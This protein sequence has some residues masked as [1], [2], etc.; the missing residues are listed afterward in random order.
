MTGPNWPSSGE[1]DIIEGVNTGSQN[2]MTMHTSDGCSLAGSDCEGNTG[3]PVI[4]GGSSSYGSGLNSA[5]G[6]MYAM[7]WTSSQISIWFFSHGSEPG[8]INSA[9]PN[10]SNWGT[11]TGSFAGGSGCDIDSHFMNNNII[12]DTTFCGDWAG[13][14]WSSDGTCSALA[15]TC[16][17]YVQNNPNAFQDAYW[18]INSL[19]VYTQDGATT[20]FDSV[21]SSTVMSSVSIAVPTSS[22]AAISSAVS[23]E[24]SSSVAS[25][26][27]TPSSASIVK[28]TPSAAPFPSGN[29]TI[30]AQPT[31]SAAPFPSANSSTSTNTTHVRPSQ[32]LASESSPTGVAN[33][34]IGEPG[35]IN[36]PGPANPS[37]VSPAEASV[38]AATQ[39]STEAG[40][41][42]IHGGFHHRH[43][44]GFGPK[45]K[46]VSRVARHLQE[47][48][49]NAHGHS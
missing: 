43:P 36:N 41:P 40:Q 4:G 19:K 9:N 24:I 34:T 32:G 18:A 45:S 23:S 5:N 12:F 42:S 22:P 28:S 27:T 17:D 11:P 29:A 8:D 39:T 35:T 3:C 6:G 26:S 16:Q 1:I 38:V 20:Q 31:A 7:E 37:I 46:R 30:I 10:P 25:S 14:V 44:P 15:S 49:R 47:H 2:Q 48:A 21:A 33:V 13:N